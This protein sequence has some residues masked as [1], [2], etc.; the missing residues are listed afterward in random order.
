MYS[1]T[2]LY[3]YWPNA[4]MLSQLKGSVEEL[5]M[6][7]IRQMELKVYS[8]QKNCSETIEYIRK[9]LTIT[10]RPLRLAWKRRLA[11]KLS[12]EI[13]MSTASCLAQ[14]LGQKV[15]MSTTGNQGAGLTNHLSLIENGGRCQ[16][17]LSNSNAMSSRHTRKVVHR[18]SQ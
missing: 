10:V 3:I 16:R 4:E 9:S 12:Q 18:V 5:P 14:K 15:P 11:Q 8:K 17:W 6:S 13:P 2:T 7:K 1:S